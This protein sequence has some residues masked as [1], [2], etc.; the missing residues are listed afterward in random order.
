MQRMVSVKAIDR[1]LESLILIGIWVSVYMEWRN[2][3]MKTKANIERRF[4]KLMKRL[5]IALPITLLILNFCFTYSQANIFAQWGI[6]NEPRGTNN[7]TAVK[8]VEFGRS[9]E[10][11]KLAYTVGGGGWIDN[12]GY[13]YK[14]GDW[15]YK[16][17]S[18]YFVESLFGV[19]PKSEHFYLNYKLGPTIISNTDAYL[20][21]NL[22]CG[23]E[24]GFGMRDIRD[25]RV[26]FVIKHMSNAGLVKP[27]LGRDWLGVRMEW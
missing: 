4:K 24:L 12:T 7:K 26:G 3:Q 19:E 25:V 10:Y 20:G 8:F 15:T 13:T 16:A 9:G 27:N 23:H 22:Q 2:L 11:G 5:S 17:S 18:S 14:S 21:S 6:A 1:I